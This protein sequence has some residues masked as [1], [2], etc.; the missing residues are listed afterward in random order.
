VNRDFILFRLLIALRAF[1]LHVAGLT[2]FGIFRI[3]SFSEVFL[4]GARKN[5]LLIALTTDQNAWLKS[6]LH[7][8]PLSITEYTIPVIGND[9]DVRV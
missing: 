7:S 3:S 5:E 4:G 8:I 2:A 6:A 1:V 9:D